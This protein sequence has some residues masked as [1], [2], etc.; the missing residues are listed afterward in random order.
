MSTTNESWESDLSRIFASSVNQQ[1]LEEAAE[2]VVDVSLDDQE[3]HNIFINAIDQG[4]RAANDGDKR[5]MNCINKSGYKVN[6]LKQALD[7]LLDFKEIYLR[8]FE[9]SKE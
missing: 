6:S 3:Y 4:I 1:S 8:E 9:Q 5:V 2:L 7:L